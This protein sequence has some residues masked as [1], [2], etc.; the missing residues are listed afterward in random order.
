MNIKKGVILLENETTLA[1]GEAIEFI[2]TFC[3]LQED[4]IKDISNVRAMS[5]LSIMCEVMPEWKPLVNFMNES[6]LHTQAIYDFVLGYK[7]IKQ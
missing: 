7:A 4:K 2:A 5:W 6:P 3:K 1:Y